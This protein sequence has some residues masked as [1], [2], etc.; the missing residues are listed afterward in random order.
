MTLLYIL[1]AIAVLLVLITVHEF[2]HYCAGKILGFK[3]DEFSVGFGP[4]LYQ[5]KKKD[6]EIFSIRALP[7]GGY[8]AFDGEDQNEDKVAN[9]KAFNNMPAW[10]R[11]IVLLAGVTFNFLFGVLTA[12]I[13]LCVTGYGTVQVAYTL[14]NSAVSVTDL[15]KNDIVISVDGKTVEA[16]RTFAS[17]IDNYEVGE[18]FVITVNRD[19]EI[20]DISVSKKM[21]NPFYYISNASY[22]ENKLFDYE[23]NVV[24]IDNF[25]ENILSCTI[26][27][28]EKTGENIAKG[29]CESLKDYLATV[30]TSET[31]DVSYADDGVF[32][33]LFMAENEGEIQPIQYVGESVGIGFLQH[34]VHQD[35]GFFEAVLKAWPFCFYLIG[36]IWGAL[37]GIFTGATALKELGG[38]I[39]AV[40]QIADISS[41]GI[42]YF[43]LLLPLL[44]MNLALFN[45]LPIPSLDGARTIFVLIELIFRK[46]VNRKV[47]G[48]IHMIGLVLLLGIVVFFDVYHFFIAAK[49]LL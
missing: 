30:Y 9:P 29:D 36:L 42:A 10:K 3:I 38:T 40:S 34:F 14:K 22:F 32:E 43:L 47:E 4:A 19:G 35:Y 13:Y 49:L 26:T 45:V 7:L 5:K 20:Q 37:V 2:G 8:C 31:H 44:A 18:E 33:T 11:I 16:Y 25:F 23:G 28:T 15:Q 41:K 6:G 46:P 27:E 17:L 21:L 48:L 1:L 39:T 12:A 24:T